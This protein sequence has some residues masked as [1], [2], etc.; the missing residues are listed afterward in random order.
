MLALM[1]RTLVLLGA[2]ALLG[3]GINALRADGVRFASFAAPSACAAG[4]AAAAAAGRSAAVSDVEVLSPREAVGLCGAP[5]TV[6]ADVRS[7]EEFAQGHVSG[8]IHL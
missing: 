6:L 4:P 8:A 2:G 7:A 5:G 3:G 1:G